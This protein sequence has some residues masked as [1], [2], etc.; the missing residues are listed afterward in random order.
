MFRC[1]WFYCRSKCSDASRNFSI[2]FDPY[3]WNESHVHGSINSCSLKGGFFSFGFFFFLAYYYYWYWYCFF[4]FFGRQRQRRRWWWC[5]WCD[6]GVV[7]HA[8]LRIVM[9]F[10]MHEKLHAIFLPEWWSYWSLCSFVRLFVFVPFFFALGCIKREPSHA[11]TNRSLFLGSDCIHSVH[12]YF[13]LYVHILV[14]EIFVYRQNFFSFFYYFI[15]ALQYFYFPF[16]D[17]YFNRFC[18]N[19]NIYY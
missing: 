14:W 10:L 5:Q 19:Q 2:V 3:S 6:A 17:S 4:F 8:N 7:G 13:Y 9:L 1:C 16:F 12:L 18:S 11:D 15:K